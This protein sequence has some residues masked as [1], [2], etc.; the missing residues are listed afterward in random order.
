[1]GSEI[2]TQYDEDSPFLLLDGATLYFS[3]KGHNS[4][5]GYDVFYATLSGKGIW[6]EL[7]NI[8]PPVNSK[9]DDVFFILSSNEKNA[10][11]SSSKN[12]ENG[13]LKIFKIIF[14]E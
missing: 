7:E 9:G 13:E 2:N 6:E 8:G 1:L 14:N 10:F 5:G 12:N 3:S 4:T 11:Y